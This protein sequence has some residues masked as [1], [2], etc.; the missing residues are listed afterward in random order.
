MAKKEE[1]KSRTL[2]NF[3]S[4][5][6]EE[7]RRHSFFMRDREESI[8]LPCS[9]FPDYP[10]DSHPEPVVKSGWL[11][12]T[13]PKGGKRFQRR[14]VQLDHKYLR[15]FQNSK[16][17]YSK[18]MISL[19]CVSAVQP[20]G[21][22]RFELITLNRTFL[23]KTE[24]NQMRN[25]WIKSL[26]EVLSSRPQS[27][28]KARSEWIKSLEEVLRRRQQN[29]GGGVFFKSCLAKTEG[30]LEMTS[31]RTKVYTVINNNRIYL[32]KNRQ[33]YMNGLGITDID[34]SKASLKESS[35]SFS[36]I[37]PYRTFSFV[38]ESEAERQ[39]W[40]ACLAECVR[41]SAPVS[42]VCEKLWSKEFNRVCADCGADSPEWASVNLCVLLCERCADAHR[43]LGPS[44]SKVFSLK[45]NDQLWTEDLIKLF[46]QLGNGKV[47]SFWAENIPSSEILNVES[48]S[49]ERLAYAT[50]KY[51]K[52][53]FRKQHHLSGQQEALNNALCAAV[54]GSNIVE[55]F[56]LLF[57][58]A[59]INSSTG[60]PEFPTPLALAMHSGQTNQVELLKHN[61]KSDTVKSEVNTAP[62]LSGYLFKVASANR[63][64][65]EQKPRSE[66]TQRW[67][68]LNAG[69]FTYY[70]TE[71]MT[72]R[73]GSMKT[74]EIICLSLNSPGNHGF[75]H[76]L[77]IYTDAG[78]VYL[79]GADDIVT[80]K[81]WFRAISMAMLP[82]ALSSVCGL[83]DRL[84]RLLCTEGSLGTGWFCLSGSMLQVLLEDSVQDIN[85]LRLHTLTIGDGAGD[86]VLG[87]R[88]GYVHL[89]FDQRPHFPGWI[90][91]LRRGAGSGNEMLSQQQLTKSGIPITVQRCIEYVTRHGLMS[92]GIYR[93]SGTTSRVSALL[94][95][96]QQDARNVCFS[97]KFGVD[98]VASTLKRFL[99]EVKGGVFN[100][101]DNSRNWLKVADVSHH[102]AKLS[103]YQN[104]LSEL[105]E[106]NRETLKVLLNHLYCVHHLSEF[107]QM[108]MG[109]LGIV[110]GPT[111][112]QTDGSDPRTYTVVEEMIQN[113]CAIFNVPEE[114]LQK[115]LD[116]TS[117]I[118][119]KINDQTSSKFAPS[120]SICAVYIEK[121][122]E[123]AELL[124]Q[125]GSNVT[126]KQLVLQVLEMRG[127]E[128][129]AEEMWT[130]YEVQ[131]KEEMERELHFEE[132][133]LP[134]Y[135]S[136]GPDCHLLV[137]KSQY[138]ND[139]KNYLSGK[140][141]VYKVG[142]L[143][144]CEVKGDKNRNFISHQC[145]L[146]KGTLKLYK[147]KES[148]L[149][150]KEWSV[151]EGT[152][153]YGYRSK[154]SPPTPW[155]LILVCGQQQWYFCCDN[156]D[157]FI[158]WMA[159][160][161]SL[162]CGENR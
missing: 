114:E 62:S 65:T 128:P 15:Y 7:D 139:I 52:G 56:R 112:F 29:G 67:C 94:D 41:S 76:T 60:I 126:A 98:D 59:D 121:K 17:V 102:R 8:D 6:V 148:S 124:V 149:C 100:G 95:S 137:K 151:Q 123:G 130:C 108:T 5:S 111:L 28:H 64:I 32:F 80:I 93:K 145:E 90:S 14:W 144:V 51:L 101:E 89:S 2:R 133:V 160:F 10:K 159:T 45:G 140:N 162:Q 11:D 85:L 79:F 141:E 18:R 120:L 122:E 35:K 61:Q 77:E 107:N 36:V 142:T 86:V 42:R 37:T 57:S 23:F 138:S 31:P 68:S 26:E 109:N 84:G 43:C 104:L 58:G 115:E 4:L 105:P 150:E 83:C 157:E 110:F 136:L 154:L 55:T 12:K 49:S 1:E 20:A 69:M 3:R 88:G 156:E 19:Q 153:Y 66:F 78:R 63:P 131:E 87:W 46:L 39:R 129:F 9:H 22:Q 70:K 50:A 158:E 155:G 13:P 25:E 40:C 132:K 27:Q 81:E 127:I 48:S 119:N 152:L 135:F 161:L 34:L 82:T 47:N 113:Y 54:K 21:D 134:F 30:L 33:E 116:A 92:A 146:T 97:D 71:Q 74:S 106:V 16:E 96:F 147:D 72:H 143:R 125:V 73:C 53:T 75:E 44:V 24:S 117:L 118:L 38:V 99:R 103:M 91:S